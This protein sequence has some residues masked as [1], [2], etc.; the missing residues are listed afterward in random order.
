[1]SDR[2]RRSLRQPTRLAATQEGKSALST[3][4]VAG[5]S[6]Q[7]KRKAPEPVDPQ[8]QLRNILE[9]PKSVLTTMDISELLNANN[10]NLLPDDS[11]NALMAL[12]PSAAFTDDLS[13]VDQ[14]RLDEAMPGSDQLVKR[15][16]NLNIFHDAHFLDAAHTFQDHLFSGWFTAAHHEK[17]AVYLDGIRNGTLSAPWKDEVWERENPH[18][19][20]PVSPVETPSS[21]ARANF[22]ANANAGASADLKLPDLVK[23]GVLRVGDIIAY[24]RNFSGVG[25]TI[26]KDAIIRSTDPL[27]YTLTVLMPKSAACS[28]PSSLTCQNP[29]D[30]GSEVVSVTISTPQMLETHILDMDARVKK[31]QRPNG[32]AW[33][34]FTVYRWRVDTTAND[35]TDQRG[36]RDVY[37]TLFYLRGS[38][39]YDR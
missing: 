16:L 27:K 15:S 11:Q 24:R 8:T 34:C 25:L 14:L 5:P 23:D 37:G 6:R 10:W 3:D 38:H 31:N 19:A 12:L 7:A 4:A 28:L 22:G 30:P 2:P 9:N 29:G 32:N 13:G 17:L 39:Y 36:G 26:Q 20:T 21:S 35:T 33:K 1:M 18:P